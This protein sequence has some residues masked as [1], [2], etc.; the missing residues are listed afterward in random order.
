MSTRPTEV[1][2]RITAEERDA[3]NGFRRVGREGDE[4]VG[5]FT[6]IGGAAVVAFA[7][8]QAG[9]AIYNGMQQ[10]INLASDLE[11]GMTK[12]AQI[13]GEHTAQ[14]E[15]LANGSAEALGLSRVQVIGLAG[16]LG[17]LFDAVDV[18]EQEAAKYST[19]LIGLSADLASFHNAQG[20]AAEVTRALRAGLA[21]EAEPLRRFGIFLSASAV[22]AKALELGLAETKKEI[23]EAD[24]ITARY[25]II[26][27]QS[28]TAQGDFARTSDGFA[29]SQRSLNAELEDFT[30]ELGNA[31]I[32]IASDALVVLGEMLDVAKDLTD[33]VGLTSFAIQENAAVIGIS[34]EAY[35]RHEAAVRLSAAQEAALLVQYR[36]GKISLSELGEI[37]EQL[38]VG[39]IAERAAAEAAR[40]AEEDQRREIEQHIP[41]TREASDALRKLTD[42][43]L[44]LIGVSR[45]QLLPTLD[46]STTLLN[47]L[48]QAG[49]DGGADVDYARQRLEEIAGTYNAQLNIGINISDEILLALQDFF[50]RSGNIELAG[51]VG[52]LYT[53][54]QR[55][56]HFQAG[57]LERGEFGVFEP[58]SGSSS[59][60]GGGGGGGGTAERP[61]EEARAL[62]ENEARGV[63]RSEGMPEEWTELLVRAMIAD[64]ESDE[65]LQSEFFARTGHRT[66]AERVLS[67]WRALEKIRDQRREEEDQRSERSVLGIGRG[68]LSELGL[69][70]RDAFRDAQEAGYSG[71]YADFTRTDAFRAVEGRTAAEGGVTQLVRLV[72]QD[73]NDV[74][75]KEVRIAP[76]GSS[77][78][79][80][81][82]N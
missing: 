16:D 72:T 7:A 4:L 62:L 25:N 26:L 49:I 32:P 59:S 3:V 82:V 31:L 36:T 56:T 23:T 41:I 78:V 70:R 28:A 45:D 8:F 50:F 48:G 67:D 20:G 42:E 64:S 6:R 57:L 12:N 39:L 30:T 69:N 29:N 60:G 55:G 75:T 34:E 5:T 33:L 15:A 65:L 9:G 63:A 1:G 11:E 52:S 53:A 54:V 58:A 2:L 18:N 68:E 79:I 46:E 71:S 74:F 27:E 40:Q 22:E 73:G 35:K 43:Q 81:G 37:R 77:S 17:A 19:T 47:A 21:G 14:I 13:F 24:K 76:D 66:R 61:A 44:E 51:S 80:P 38:I 10:A